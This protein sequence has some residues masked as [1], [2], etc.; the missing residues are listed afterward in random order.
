[1]NIEVSCSILVPNTL[2]VSC[3]VVA[4]AIRIGREGWD[5]RDSNVDG[6]WL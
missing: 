3:A 4:M 1:V 5:V 2:C 6:G